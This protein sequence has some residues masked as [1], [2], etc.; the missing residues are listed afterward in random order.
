MSRL[1]KTHFDHFSIVIY[2]FR[3]SQWVFLQDGK[4]LSSEKP[5]ASFGPASIVDVAAEDSVL[6]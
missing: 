4:I 5:G 6:R 2:L 3:Y 1:N